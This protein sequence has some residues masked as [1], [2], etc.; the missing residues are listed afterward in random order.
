MGENREFYY[1]GYLLC[2]CIV[3]TQRTEKGGQ[4]TK[5]RRDS[6]VPSQEGGID[7]TVAFR[8]CMPLQYVETE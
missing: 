2:R 8:D 4:Q 3:V 7:S 6:A 5:K 1:I